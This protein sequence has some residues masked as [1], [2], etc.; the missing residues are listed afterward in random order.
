M[1]ILRGFWGFRTQKICVE[2]K[3][4]KESLGEILNNSYICE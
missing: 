1:P 2:I 4:I 3:K